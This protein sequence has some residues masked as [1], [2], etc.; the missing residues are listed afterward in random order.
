MRQHLTRRLLGLAVL[1]SL[2]ACSTSQA[3]MFVTTADGNG[4][5]TSLQNDGQSG[6][7]SAVVFGAATGADYRRYDDVRQKM[8]LV[9]FDISSL[10]TAAYADAELWFYNETNRSRTLRV[11]AI[12][13]GPLDNWDESTTSYSNAP[14]ILQPPTGA[15]Y[16]SAANNFLDPTQLF[17]PGAPPPAPNPFQLGIIQTADTRG[18]PGGRYVL[19]SDTATLDLESVLNADTNGLVSFLLFHD[20]SDS[21]QTGNIRTK[22]QGAPF[23]PKLGVIPLD[24]VPEPTTACLAALSLLGLA[25]RRR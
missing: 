2:L 3:A 21:A 10:D 18:L 22:E 25:S 8:L 11:Y 13:D 5:D 1:A 4:A 12:A 20:G 23:A 17:N 14:G 19:Q 6:G 7:T 24:F 16:D 15:A 9:R